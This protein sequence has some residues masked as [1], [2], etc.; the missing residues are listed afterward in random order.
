VSSGAGQASTTFISALS[1][2]ISTFAQQLNA[3]KQQQRSDYAVLLQEEQQLLEELA[4]L[5]LTLTSTPQEQQQQ[6]QIEQQEQEPALPRAWPVPAANTGSSLSQHARN[7]ST[8]TT[9]SRRRSS[10]TAADCVC[11]SP[12]RP[13]RHTGSSPAKGPNA[14]GASSNSSRGDIHAKGSSS[15]SAGVHAMASST[16]S[17][18][19][20]PPEVQAYDAF[21][22]RH[23]ATGG[24]HPEDHA[25]F[26][27]I[28]KAHRWGKC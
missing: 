20:L 5:E 10:D 16:S 26:M 2:R 15:S 7:T 13:G 25:T 3:I 24:W 12:D 21:L 9:S 27:A 6:Q 17:S 22:T 1:D 28:L 11:T 8:T 23:G 18:S 19:G 4:V 14:G